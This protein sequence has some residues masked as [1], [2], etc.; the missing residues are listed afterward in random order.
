MRFFKIEFQH[1]SVYFG[2]STVNACHSVQIPVT[3]FIFL[4]PF[5]VTLIKG[6]TS[7][8][9]SRVSFMDQTTLQSWVHHVPVWNY[10]SLK[11]VLSQYWN[12]NAFF[13]TPR[14][15]HCSSLFISTERHLQ[16]LLVCIFC[17]IMVFFF[18]NFK[19]KAAFV[20]L[21]WKHFS[22]CL[23]CSWY[24]LSHVWL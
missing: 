16:Q 8:D 15:S 11:I 14:L 9:I 18:F 20:N 23:H 21:S 13:K 2:Q 6:C 4:V 12:E 22:V 7:N 3:R 5:M 19:F 1:S 10:S 17:F 24:P